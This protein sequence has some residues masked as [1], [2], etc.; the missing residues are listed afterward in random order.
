MIAIPARKWKP[1]SI[2]ILV[3]RAEREIRRRRFSAC[4]RLLALG[5]TL[6]ADMDVQERRPHRQYLDR[7]TEELMQALTSKRRPLK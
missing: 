4:R 5:E 1:K 2:F 7:L 6:L 3:A